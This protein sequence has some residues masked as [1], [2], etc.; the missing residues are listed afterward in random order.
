[1]DK[2]TSKTPW[3]YLIGMGTDGLDSLSARARNHLDKA[4][5]LV[6]SS[7]LFKL[8]PNDGRPRICWDS[9]LSETLPKIEA[10]RGTATAIIATGDPLSFGVGTW[11]LTKF[12]LNEMVIIPGVSAFSLACARMGWTQQKTKLV[13]LH[14][15]DDSDIRDAIAPDENIVVLSED[16]RTPRNVAHHLK[17][18]GFGH[19]ELTVFT[20]MDGVAERR[21]DVYLNQVPKVF[22][23]SF[24]QDKDNDFNVVAVACG[25]CEESR[26]SI[27][28]RAAGL[29]DEMFTPF[30]KMTKRELRALAL[31][32]LAPQPGNV[33]WDVGAGSATI[34]IE[35]LRLAQGGCAHAFDIDRETLAY[36]SRN[37]QAFGLSN[38]LMSH[39]HA[40]PLSLKDVTMP[41]PDALFLGGGI[42]P[43]IIEAAVSHLK[44]RGRLVAHA[45]TIESEAFLAAAFGK[46]G[47][48]L[49]RISV[50]RSEAI[51][52]RG[53]RDGHSHKFHG[54]KPA[55]TVT[56]WSLVKEQIL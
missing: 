46:Y 45:V 3:I 28:S 42:D 8:I 16:A 20:H 32:K 14:G 12:P 50:A 31:A 44:A 36:Q 2:P 29:P 53:D 34:S 24:E 51:G 23:A 26:G 15:R 56:Q 19:S 49:T 18:M 11:L 22:D 1:M 55:M 35:F 5:I 27:V 13:T 48:D 9:P 17:D 47:G 52:P 37:A 7:R 10:H 4:E 30:S 21:F 33:L 43:E 54:F 6:S 38:A 41:L 25:S 39:Q 40:M